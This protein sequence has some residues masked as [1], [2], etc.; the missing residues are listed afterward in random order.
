MLIAAQGHFSLWC[1]M[2]TGMSNVLCSLFSSDVFR[3]KFYGGQIVKEI[4]LTPVRF[5]WYKN[6][7]VMKDKHFGLLSVN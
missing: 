6:C 2:Q 5:G 3:D 7:P 4:F 1:I